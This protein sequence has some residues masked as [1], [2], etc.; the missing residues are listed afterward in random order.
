MGLGRMGFW[1][2][3]LDKSE[4]LLVWAVVLPGMYWHIHY[5]SRDPSLGSPGQE[6][7]QTSSC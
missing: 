1:E 2:V 7:L 4:V 6:L 5:N 3:E